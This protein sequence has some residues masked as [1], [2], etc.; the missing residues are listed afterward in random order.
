MQP[1]SRL[2]LYEARLVRLWHI[3]VTTLGI[4][5]V[6][7][8]LDRA[9]WQTAQRHPDIALLQHGDSGLSF[10]ALERSYATQSQEEF[11]A[12]F[13]DLLT[14]MLLILTR[15]LDREMAQGLAAERAVEDIAIERCGPR[16]N[17]APS[18]SEGA[19]DRPEG[20]VG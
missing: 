11:E 7:V 8:L 1:S 13:N 20:F 2:A 15:L 16:I 17:D 18:G 5:T 6:H 14:E 10:E 19:L 3:L 12:A 9:V 4:H